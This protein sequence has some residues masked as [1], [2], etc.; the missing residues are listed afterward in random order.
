MED[1]EQRSQAA[2]DIA[3]GDLEPSEA[4]SATALSGQRP[5]PDTASQ[6]V[7]LSQSLEVTSRQGPI[8]SPDDLSEYEQV[9]PGLADRIVK[10]AESQILHQQQIE[11]ENFEFG[12]KRSFAGLRAGFLI[13]VLFL[14]A[15]VWLVLADHDT[16]GI[17]LGSVDLVGLVTVFVLGRR[18]AA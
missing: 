6:E 9:L 12:S 1:D 15:A 13:A 17:I 3:A 7:L 16:A 5:S 2:E 18:D 4:E 8:P 11:R 10:M 14:C